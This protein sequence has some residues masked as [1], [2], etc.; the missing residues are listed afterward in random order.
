[1]RVPVVIEVASVIAKLLCKKRSR[2]ASN[3]RAKV[4]N[5]RHHTFSVD[6]C[7]GRAESTSVAAAKIRQFKGRWESWLGFWHGEREGISPSLL[8]GMLN[9]AEQRTEQSYPG[10]VGGWSSLMWRL[11]CLSLKLSPFI[12]RMLTW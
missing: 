3:W 12:S 8:H 2:S 10:S 6:R 4:K 9:E 7:Q 1:M 11:L 5:H